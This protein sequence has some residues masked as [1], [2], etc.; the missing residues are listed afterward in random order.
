VVSII[1]TAR[2]R[3]LILRE[4]TRFP[5]PGKDSCQKHFGLKELNRP[6]LTS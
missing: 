2:A 3:V 5:Y 4:E 6:T 1:N